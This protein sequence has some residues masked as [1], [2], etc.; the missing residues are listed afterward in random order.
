MEPFLAFRLLAEPHA[1]F[2]LFQMGKNIIFLY[3]VIHEKHRL[4]QVYV[5][6]TVIVA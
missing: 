3:L 4:I 5:C 2:V 1:G 6:N